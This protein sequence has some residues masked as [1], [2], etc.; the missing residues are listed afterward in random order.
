[1]RVAATYLPQRLLILAL[2]LCCVA[3]LT[4][5]EQ[6]SP[7]ATAKIDEAVSQVMNSGRSAG[8]ALAIAHNGQVVFAK[9]YGFANL[10]DEAR[11]QADTVFRIG[12]VTKQF[13][14]AAIMILAEKGKLSVND[15][16]SKF[17]PSFPRG[18]EVT[19][20]ELLN[21][22]SGIHD[23]LDAEYFQR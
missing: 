22:T 19:I 23:Y 20:R 1:M 13:T 2:V 12:S 5:Q 21:H 3:P 16:L 17:F 8:I 11:V 4:A 10:E 7:A 15:K 18:N 9:G 14:A 6:L